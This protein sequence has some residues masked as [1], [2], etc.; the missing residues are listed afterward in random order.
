[1]EQYEALIEKHARLNQTLMGLKSPFFHFEGKKYWIKSDLN[2]I[3]ICL[4]CS[5]RFVYVLIKSD[6]N[7]IE[8]KKQKNS[9]YDASRLNQTLMGLKL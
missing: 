6:L 2:G 4:T 7:G 1:M 5:F 3:E 8:M 9:K